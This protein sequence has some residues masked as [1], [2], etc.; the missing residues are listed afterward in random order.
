MLY[1]AIRGRDKLLQFA[2]EIKK[3]PY[4]F[5]REKSLTQLAVLTQGFVLGY[6]NACAD[7]LQRFS[8]ATKERNIWGEFHEFFIKKYNIPSIYHLEKIELCGSEERAFDL[9]FEELEYYL[10]EHKEDIPR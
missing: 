6:N 7:E 10:K 5:L 8:E 9:F 1:I 4:L 3:Q 2:L